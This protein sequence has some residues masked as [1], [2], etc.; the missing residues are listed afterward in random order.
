MNN[1]LK[2]FTW[3]FAGFWLLACLVLVAIVSFFKFNMEGAN[4]V[5]LIAGLMSGNQYLLGRFKKEYS[6]IVDLKSF[7]RKLKLQTTAIA[8]VI[9]IVPSL[10]L[11]PFIG[12][13][14][15]FILIGIVLNVLVIYIVQLIYFRKKKFL[16]L[17][18]ALPA[19]K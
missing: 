9:S 10:V 11:L 6:G 12:I 17:Q 16:K 14:F 15:Q 7:L 4:A 1:Y 3:R 8:S 2:Q 5:P 18:G 19:A 13:P